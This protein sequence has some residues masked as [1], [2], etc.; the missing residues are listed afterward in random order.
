LAKEFEPQPDTVATCLNTGRYSKEVAKDLHDAFALG[1]TSTPTFVINGYP[2]V[3]ARPF[4][5]F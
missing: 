3:R 4:A 2:L 1:T 5:E